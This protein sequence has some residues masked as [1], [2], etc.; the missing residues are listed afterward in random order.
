MKKRS[1]SGSIAD[2]QEAENESAKTKVKVEKF[3]NVHRDEIHLSE[4]RKC[5]ERPDGV[6]TGAVHPLKG[7]D[8]VEKSEDADDD[9]VYPREDKRYNNEKSSRAENDEAHSREENTADFEGLDGANSSEVKKDVEK[10][11]G[12]ENDAA[13]LSEENKDIE[14]P[15]GP[16]N[17]AA[18]RSEGE[19]EFDKPRGAK[20]DAAHHNEE[21]KKEE[22]PQGAEHD[23]VHLSK[24]TKEIDKS[25]GAEDNTAH[26]SKEKKP[27][28]KTKG[29]E[30]EALHLSGG[31]KDVKQT[32]GAKNDAVHFGEG[33]IDA[34]NS[35]SSRNTESMTVIFHALLTPTFNI[36]FQ[37]GDKVVLRGGSPFSWK[38]TGQH[39]E[40]HPV[41]YELILCS[42]VIFL[43]LISLIMNGKLCKNVL[44]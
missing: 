30:K 38:Q 42:F 41:R 10:S 19:I 34:R 44:E 31:N 11:K 27:V 39:I 29:A 13:H 5:F 17:E 3:D 23:A 2:D 40:M 4:E 20:N 22:K 16:E 15:E 24:E 28:E 12:A 37:Q 36:N 25:T 33:N 8:V 32:Q 35:G 18:H 43:L 6:E 1:S 21:T 9:T 26:S 14:R 7:E